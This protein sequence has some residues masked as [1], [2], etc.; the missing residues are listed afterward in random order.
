MK[1]ILT[2]GVLCFVHNFVN[3]K[4]PTI[5]D[6][7]FTKFNDIHSINTRN[8]DKFIIPKHRTV[9]GSKT[10]KYMGAIKWNILDQKIKEIKNIKGFRKV[11]KKIYLTEII[12]G[13]T[14]FHFHFVQKIYIILI[15]DFFTFFLHKPIYLVS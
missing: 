4:L 7:Y 9:L 1:D 6:N 15:N 14:I 13:Q 10:I 11:W 5:F 12:T 8:K 3:N 2:Q